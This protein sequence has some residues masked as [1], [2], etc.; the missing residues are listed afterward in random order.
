MIERSECYKILGLKEGASK[1]EIRKRYNILIKKLK[2]MS[3]EGKHDKS[4]MDMEEINSAYNLLMGYDTGEDIDKKPFKPNP[5]LKKMGVDEKKARNFIYYY[6]FQMIGAVLLLIAV[7]FF[8]KDIVFKAPSD[9]DTAIIGNINYSDTEMLKKNLMEKMPELKEMTIDGVFITDSEESGMG[10][11]MNMKS[12]VLFGS[13]TIDLFLL[14]KD[15][16][17][18]YAVQGVFENLDSF[19]DNLNIDNQKSKDLLV[20]AEDTNEEHL[21]GIDIT[22]SLILKESEVIGDRIIAAIRINSKHHENAMRMLEL[23]IK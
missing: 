23:L 20:K 19:A 5:I 9:L 14:D 13:G 1:D 8:F 7:I 21:Y 3:S 18:E 6:K 22:D 17:E 4:E 15:F 10:Y 16:Y 11:A 2:L 12:I